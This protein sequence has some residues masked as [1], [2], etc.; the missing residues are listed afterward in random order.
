MTVYPAL[1]EP[2]QEGGFVV[3]FPDFGY[4]VTQG[5]TESEAREMASDLLGCLIGDCIAAGT[6]LP[7]PSAH[8]GSLTRMVQPSASVAAKAELYAAFRSAGIRKDEL[9]DRLRVSATSIDR[10]FDVRYASQIDQLESA[11]R[12]MGKGM[13]IAIRDAA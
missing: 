8:S 10:L 11:F 5:D 7:P 3:R 4:G 1:F 2:A 13:S 6:E 12:A 9:A